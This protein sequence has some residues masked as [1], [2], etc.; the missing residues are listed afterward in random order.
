MKKDKLLNLDKSKNHD[1]LDLNKKQIM[2]INN[3]STIEISDISNL[4]GRCNSFLNF[5]VNLF[6]S[7]CSGCANVI[8]WSSSFYTIVVFGVVS[9]IMLLIP[10]IY[11]VNQLNGL[12]EL[13][14]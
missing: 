11:A 9:I 12:R 13:F 7:I 1:W 5:S 3:V 8:D 6:K 4:N 14:L 2:N 10:Y